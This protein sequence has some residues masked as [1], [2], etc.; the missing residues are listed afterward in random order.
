MKT[1]YLSYLALGLLLGIGSTSVALAQDDGG[2]WDR[3][4]RREEQKQN[5]QQDAQTRTDSATGNVGAMTIRDEPMSSGGWSS[6]AGKMKASVASTTGKLNSKGVRT[7]NSVADR[8]TSDGR[9]TAKT[10]SVASGNAATKRPVVTTLITITTSV[11]GATIATAMGDRQIETATNGDGGKRTHGVNVRRT[12]G[13]AKMIASV[14]GRFAI[15][16][17]AKCAVTINGGSNSNI[18]SGCGGIRFAYKAS[19]TW[20]TVTRPTATIAT[21]T[22]TT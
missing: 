18:A 16:T 10:T 21:T 13:A 2:K 3:G 8:K 15:S 5:N 17:F 19:H 1:R 7:T 6:S 14:S 12:F 20:I 11:G 4:K 22:A 9:V